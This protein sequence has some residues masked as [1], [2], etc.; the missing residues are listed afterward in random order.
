[1]IGGRSAPKTSKHGLN[2]ASRA[3][4]LPEKDPPTPYDLGIDNTDSWIAT[5]QGFEGRNAADL[6]LSNRYWSEVLS[7]FDNTAT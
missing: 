1:M 4:V 5:A 7:L 3:G 6:C 2:E